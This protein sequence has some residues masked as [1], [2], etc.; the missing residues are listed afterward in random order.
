MFSK[1]VAQLDK[2]SLPGLCRAECPGFESRTDQSILQ[3]I[4]TC[5]VSVNYY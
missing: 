1:I 5:I 2:A 3:E 4:S